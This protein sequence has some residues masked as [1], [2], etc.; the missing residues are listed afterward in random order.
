MLTRL[1][2]LRP[3]NLTLGKLFING[4]FVRK[5]K[6]TIFN[7][8]MIITQPRNEALKEDGGLGREVTGRL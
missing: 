4:K 2:N 6:E 7:K 1:E 3:I 5:D 8:V